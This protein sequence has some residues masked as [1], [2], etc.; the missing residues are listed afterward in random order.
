MFRHA[1]A[2]SVNVVIEPRRAGRRPRLCAR[3]RVSDNGHGMEP[4]QKLGF[5]LVGMRERILALGGTL[6]VGSGEGGLPWRRWFR[7]RRPDDPV[8]AGKFPSGKIPDLVGKTGADSARPFVAGALSRRRIH[9]SQPNGENQNS[10]W[11]R[12]G[13]GDGQAGT[14]ATSADGLG[15]DGAGVGLCFGTRRSRAGRGD[16]RPESAGGRDRGAAADSRTAQ[17]PTRPVARRLRAPASPRPQTAFTSTRPHRASGS[18][19][20]DKIPAAINAVDASQI[21]RTALAGHRR[22]LAAV[23]AW[24]QHQ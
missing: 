8:Q 21:R 4:G 19:D 15:L 5:G 3:V 6:N 16:Q 2:T 14:R 10:R 18:I 20:V 22:C 9:S 11:L 1:G 23:R 13:N 7:R 17:A 12:V 24:S